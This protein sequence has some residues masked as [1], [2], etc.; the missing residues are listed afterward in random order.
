MIILADQ[1]TKFI[2]Y[3]RRLLYT[4]FVQDSSSRKTAPLFD[5]NPGYEVVA[6][7]VWVKAQF[8][9]VSLTSCTVYVI[10]GNNLAL[11]SESSRSPIAASVNVAPNDFNGSIGFVSH[12]LTN[13]LNPTSLYCRMVHNAITGGAVLTAGE[14]DL[15]VTLARLS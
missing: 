10:A 6:A 15:W 8:V 9:A 3:K 4:D 12:T 2:T 7:K 13:Q 11:T 5:V 14:F 1:Y